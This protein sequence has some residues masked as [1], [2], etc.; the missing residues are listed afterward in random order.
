MPDLQ[1]VIINNEPDEPVKQCLALPFCEPVDV[2]HVM[3]DG[4]NRLP[5]GDGIGTNNGVHGDEFFADVFGGPAGFGVDFESV[6]LGSFVEFW[7][8]VGGS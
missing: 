2:L 5:A 6:S 7:L 4:E 1:I 8:G 3:P